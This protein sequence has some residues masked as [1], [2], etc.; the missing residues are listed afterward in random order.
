[1]RATLVLTLALVACG[2]TTDGSRNPASPQ[3]TAPIAVI[4]PRSVGEACDLTAPQACR[5]TQAGGTAY[6]WTSE[7]GP[8][9]RQEVPGKLG[10]I[11]RSNTET[12]IALCP[13]NSVCNMG[14]N[15][16]TEG[17]LVGFWWAP[18]VPLASI[19][20]DVSAELRYN[21][22]ATGNVT[23]ALTVK[24][25]GDALG[26][27][28]LLGNY[29][30][31]GG[32]FDMTFTYTR[33]A[34]TLESG[35]AVTVAEGTCAKYNDCDAFVFSENSAFPEPCVCK[36]QTRAFKIEGVGTSMLGEE[37]GEDVT[38]YLER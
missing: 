36:V 2:N 21:F 28:T 17:P 9:C 30:A 13:Q 27:V 4:T 10:D 31:Q 38:F 5:T 7:Q 19:N 32:G 11:C 25:G 34:G 3:S 37:F 6:C 29:V 22:E 20:G 26:T 12:T 24:Q 1:M 8:V 14:T 16:C 18:F 33:A 15:T 23:Y 35:E